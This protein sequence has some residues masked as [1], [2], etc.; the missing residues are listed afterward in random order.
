M[1]TVSVIVPT[2]NEEFYIN[3]C[4]SALVDQDYDKPVE[5]IVV[6]A[7]SEDKTKEI[8]KEYSDKVIESFVRNIGYQNNLGTYYSNPEANLYFYTNA[9][10]IVPKNWISRIMEEFERD[11]KT[12]MAGTIYYPISEEGYQT[13]Y[14]FWNAAKRVL[15]NFSIPI[16]PGC[17][18]AISKDTFYKLGRFSTNVSSDADMT[19]KARRIGNVRLIHDTAVLTST[20]RFKRK[21]GKFI[22]VANPPFYHLSRGHINLRKLCNLKE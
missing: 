15:D 16:I 11:K 20:R 9:D 2:A 5:I 8:A 10:T 6:D 3:R 17:S 12:V 1:N 13:F 7:Y 21:H 19:L 14:H 4:L 18:M 22:A